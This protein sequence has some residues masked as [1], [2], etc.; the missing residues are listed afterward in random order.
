MTT[1]RATAVVKAL[2][3]AV[4]LI[5]LLVGVPYVLLVA[6]GTPSLITVHRPARSR[7]LAQL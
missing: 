7:R 5:A 3:A 6:A 1:H 4:L 2:A